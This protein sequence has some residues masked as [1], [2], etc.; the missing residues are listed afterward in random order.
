MKKL[1]LSFTIIIPM[2]FIGAFILL[3][4]QKPLFACWGQKYAGP[5]VTLAIIYIAFVIFFFTFAG[6][7]FCVGIAL[8]R[9]GKYFEIT[10][11]QK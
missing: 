5:M 3:I 4:L 1:I 8:D 11:V 6:L 7:I 9:H 10:E 2:F